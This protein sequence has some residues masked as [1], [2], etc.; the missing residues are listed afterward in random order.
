MPK[1]WIETELA[2]VAD[3]IM[4]QSP[5]SSS[6]NEKGDGLPFFQGKSEFT[7]LYPIV[8]KWCTDPSKTAEINDILLSVRAPV[9]AVN[10]ADI[11]C[12]IGRGLA[13]IR[14]KYRANNKFIFYLLKNFEKE[15]NAK[16]TGSTFEAVSKKTVEEL[17]IPIPP[18]PEQQRIVER[19]DA[20]M[21]RIS[22]SKARLERIP[23]ILKN[24]RQSVLAAAVSGE[25]TKEWRGE[26]K[27]ET[28]SINQL[29]EI[30]E[31]NYLSVGVKLEKENKSIPKLPE[32]SKLENEN[33][34][35]GWSNITVES[36]AT[37]IIDCLHNTPVFTESG[38]YCIDTTCIKPFEILWHNARKVTID[39]FKERTSRMVPEMGDILFSR[40]GTIGTA[41]Y[42]KGE[43]P[44]CLGQRMMMFRF[45]DFVLPQYAEYYLSSFYFKSQY[46]PFI[47]GTSAQH[48][49]I[50]DIRKLEFIIPPVDEQEEIVRKVQELFQF[51]DSIEA[52]YQKAKAWFDKLPQSLLAKAFRGEL[53]PQ[54]EADEPAAELLKRIQAE[55]AGS[56]SKSPRAAKGKKAYTINRDEKLSMA[57][58]E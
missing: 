54:N 11:K 45:S 31:N 35:N 49:N 28:L 51:A 18:L 20:L 3:I 19:L 16:A 1:G 55:K 23:A 53:V 25:L 13:A 21:A 48:L 42:Y 27:I 17:T 41:V 46:S 5:P 4:G 10:I 38:K 57:A 24:F 12:C 43:F 44:I 9:G 52:R 39:S 22:S 56:A 29:K 14:F 58:E 37:F 47:T 36:A 33:L 34:P 15:L 7:E 2:A 8:K 26:N 30:R 50:G 6:Y 40:E 32:F